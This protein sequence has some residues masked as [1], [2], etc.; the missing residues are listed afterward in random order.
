MRIIDATVG[1]HP[2]RFCVQ[3]PND[4][5]R[6]KVIQRYN[7]FRTIKTFPQLVVPKIVPNTNKTATHVAVLRFIVVSPGL[8]PGQAEPKTAVLPL[9]HETIFMLLFLKS[10]AKIRFFFLTAKQKPDFLPQTHPVLSCNKEEI[11]LFSFLH[12]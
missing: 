1:N 2:D 12:K 5:N 6:R 4:N 10:G 11:I 7:C 3:P 8:E 9:H